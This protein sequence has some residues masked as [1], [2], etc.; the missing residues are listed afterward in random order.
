MS[1]TP[2]FSSLP[3]P[4][5]MFVHF[6]DSSTAGGGISTAVQSLDGHEEDKLDAVVH[7]V[8]VRDS[9]FEVTLDKHDPDNPQSWSPTYRAW[10]MGT[11][12]FSAWIVVLYSTSYMSCVPG[13]EAEFRA[14]SLDA[15]MGMTTYL[16]GLAF[17][18]L[19]TAPISELY[20]RR[21]VYLVCLCIWTLLVIPCGL[22]HSLSAIIAS[23]F[24]G[25]IF[26]AAMVSNGPG[27]IVDVS[28][29]DQLALGMSLY[30]LGPFSGPVLGPLIGGV[31]FEYLG[32]RWTNWIII[33]LG[34]VGILMMSTVKETYTPEIL[35]R[36]VAQLRRET[37]DDRWWCQYDRDV[38]AFG[39]IKGNLCRPIVLFFTEPMVWFINVWNAIVY[40]ILYLCFVAYPVVFAKHRG[41][42]PTLSGMSYLGIGLGILIPIVMEPFIRRMI[43]SRPCDPVTGRPVPEVVALVM[44]IGSLLSPIGQFGFAWTCLP[45]SIHWIVPLLFG[46]P[47]GA[48]NTLSFIYSSSY[49]GRAYGIYA[50]SALASNA[51]IRSI[52]G[53]VL[54]LAATK[55]YTTMSPQIAGTVCGAMLVMMIPIPFVFWRYGHRIRER[56]KVIRE[57]GR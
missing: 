38:S 43:N 19:F 17:G 35:R 16:V 41:W 14:S 47:F 18:S 3:S 2:P 49:L 36:K 15:T 28:K 44:A 39:S 51:V 10:V 1:A 13:L 24:C 31:V 9:L 57:I 12:A 46:I 6:D 55:M 26:A 21:I 7:T 53:A 52:F 23:R 25:G 42:G 32:R 50:A 37:K 27:S 22:A 34:C 11:V 8:V 48:G 45:T 54:P 30:S 56:S 5:P 20:G 29:P 4:S 40:G 33:I